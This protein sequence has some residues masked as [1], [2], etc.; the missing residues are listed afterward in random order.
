[1]VGS[2]F[3]EECLKNFIRRSWNWEK[4]I[5]MGVSHAEMIKQDGQRLNVIEENSS[6]RL[7]Q[8]FVGIAFGLP[9][10]LAMWAGLITLAYKYFF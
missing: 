9:L 3:A 6:C 4:E 5:M 1:M 10:S 7:G 2:Y 8:C